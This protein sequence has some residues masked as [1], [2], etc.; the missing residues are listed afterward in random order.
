[1]LQVNLRKGSALRARRYGGVETPPFQTL[2]MSHGR[3][4]G[5]GERFEWEE[6]FLRPKSGQSGDWRSRGQKQDDGAEACLA[7][8]GPVATKTGPRA[9][10][11]HVGE[12]LPRSSDGHSVLCP[13]GRGPRTSDSLGG[14]FW[15][16][17]FC[18]GDYLGYVV[19]V[20]CAYEAGLLGGAI[21]VF[22]GS[23]GAA[24][25]KFRVGFHAGI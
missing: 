1:M 15:G 12:V 10:I 20:A 9:A 17:R 5:R 16:G 24:F 19:E 6:A 25:L 18:A 7:V 11:A 14:I 8:G 3:W 4:R 13:Y 22:F 23:F 21:A 2:T